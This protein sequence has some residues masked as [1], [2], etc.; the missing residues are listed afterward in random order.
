MPPGGPAA[1]SPASTDRPATLPRVPPA[2]AMGPPPRVPPAR[3]MGPPPGLASDQWPRPPV[4]DWEDVCAGRGFAA[5]AGRCERAWQTAERAR[6]TRSTP[7]APP[8]RPYRAWGARSC[9]QRDVQPG[10]WSAAGPG[11]RPVARPPVA[12]WEARLCRPRVRRQGRPVRTC[13]ADCRTGPKDQIDLDRAALAT[14]SCL[15]ST[16]L[17]PT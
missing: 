6:R 12:D 7:I 11:L 8:S 2:R 17:R 1:I 15:G 9:G 3:A 10:P 4:A 16:F 13:L 14:I 5:R